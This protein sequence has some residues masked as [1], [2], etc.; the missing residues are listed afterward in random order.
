MTQRPQYPDIPPHS[1]NNAAGCNSCF[2]WRSDS[3]HL[4]FP[5]HTPESIR[6]KHWRQHKP[7]ISHKGGPV[8][9]YK[10]DPGSRSRVATRSVAIVAAAHVLTSGNRFSDTHN[11]GEIPACSTA[12]N[13][14]V[15]PESCCYFITDQQHFRTDHTIPDLFQVIC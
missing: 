14:P 15:R 7:G 5:D 8:H 12:H 6:P 4:S 10:G 11:I 1:G 3:S 9:K 2:N 13:F